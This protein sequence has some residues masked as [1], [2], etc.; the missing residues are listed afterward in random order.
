VTAVSSIPE[1]RPTRESRRT[2]LELVHPARSARRSTERRPSSARRRRFMVASALVV[3]AAS[4][5]ATV[6][7]HA[8]LAQGQFRLERLQSRADEE[9]ARYERLRL[10]V[11]ELESPSRV[12]AV[13]QKRLG[14]VP[15]PGVT[16]L[17]PTGSTADQVAKPGG[18]VDEAATED[19]SSVKRQLAGR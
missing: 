15:P 11:A 10:R 8:A 2:A 9:Q 7:A 18:G 6:A 3:L 4:L 13:A 14:M 16:Y 17:A 12:V 1:P 19:W 5:L